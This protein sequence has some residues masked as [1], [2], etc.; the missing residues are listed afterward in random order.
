[1]GTLIRA[2]PEGQDLQDQITLSFYVGVSRACSKI[3]VLSV[4][5]FAIGRHMQIW[6]RGMGQEPAK[7]Q[8]QDSFD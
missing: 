6:M 5:M 4:G 3:R 2:P 8:K 7:L 1:M